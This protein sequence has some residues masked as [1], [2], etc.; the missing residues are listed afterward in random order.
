M[1]NV[2][3]GFSSQDSTL[4]DSWPCLANAIPRTRASAVHQYSVPARIVRGESAR[5][6]D[7]PWT[8]R[9]DIP[10]WR[11]QL[12]VSPTLCT[13]CVRPLLLACVGVFTYMCMCLVVSV[14]AS[15]QL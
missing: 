9:K 4:G 5:L 10:L 2:T 13:Q 12:C 3:V 1:F 8:A 6:K 15:T 7:L 14:C 11:G